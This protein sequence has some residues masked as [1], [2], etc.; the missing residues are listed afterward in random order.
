MKKVSIIILNWNGES[1][2][3]DFLPSV[4]AHTPEGLADIIVADNGSTDRSVEMLKNE[5]PS[6]RLIPFDR[7]YGFADGY[8]RAIS[9]VETPYA[10][11]LNNDVEATAGWTEAPIRAMEAD[12]MLAGVQPK[13]LARQNKK[14]FEYA[15]A[16]GGWI[17][18]YGY[19]FCRGRVLHV[20]ENDHG[21]YDSTATIFWASGAC[22]FIRTDVF[23]KEGGFDARFFAHQEEIDLC[24]RL[25]ARGYRLECI[26][27]SVV[28]HVGGATL[29]T[30]SPQKTF[31]NFRNNLLMVYKNT[32]ADM[33]QSVMRVR[34]WL[35]YVALTKFFLTGHPA[36]AKAVIQARKAFK[37]LKK[38]YAPV[39][40]E[41]LS[42]TAVSSIPEMFRKSLIITFYLKGRR[43]FADFCGYEL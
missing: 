16:A 41:N 28:Y 37:T 23:K 30:E 20:V 2:L 33:L 21:Q 9:Q 12:R 19:P 14:K 11:L 3:K 25:R 39:R 31:L 29:K 6:V 22:F 40:E 34:F 4:I 35:D 26:P 32:S 18:R 10:V 7:N 43:T 1:L 8:N 15:G 38:E 13:I 24:W 5:F 17:D 42:K 36:N 27:Q